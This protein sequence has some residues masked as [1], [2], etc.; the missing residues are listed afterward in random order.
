MVREFMEGRDRYNKPRVDI[1]ADAILEQIKTLLHTPKGS[2][3]ENPNLGFHHEALKFRNI[4]KSELDAL[5]V[6]LKEQVADIFPDSDIDISF[7]VDTLD[8][9]EPLIFSILQISDST[10]RMNMTYDSSAGYWM[11]NKDFKL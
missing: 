2:I 5:S 11:S 9:G 6:A 1:G 8:S 4:N 7:H 10:Y 3:P